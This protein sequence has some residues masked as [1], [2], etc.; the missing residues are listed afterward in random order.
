[1]SNHPDFIEWP[2]K[3]GKGFSVRIWFKTMADALNW[4]VGA[5]VVSRENAQDLLRND[6]TIKIAQVRKESRWIRSQL[7]KWLRV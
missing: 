5:G 6:E 4:M 2:T 7:K 1:M 3:H